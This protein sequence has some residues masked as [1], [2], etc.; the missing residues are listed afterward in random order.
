MMNMSSIRIPIRA[1]TD[2]RAWLRWPWLSLAV[3]GCMQWPLPDHEDWLAMAE[4]PAFAT[5]SDFGEPDGESLAST[6]AAQSQDGA[7][8]TASDGVAWRT[9]LGDAEAPQVAASLSATGGVVFV[10]GAVSPVSSGASDA[11]LTAISSSDGSVLWTHQLGSSE[12]DAA[13]G[14]ASRG[15]RVVIAGQTGGSLGGPAQ[16]FGDAFVAA[17]SIAGEPLWTQQLGGPN[18][19][20][21][22]GVSLDSNGAALVVGETRSAL[23]GARRGSDRDAFL[24][25]VGP[26]GELVYARQLGSSLGVDEVATSVA[27]DANG[28]VVLAG[29]TFGSV[30]GES[31]GS[32]DILVARYSSA[33][34]LL[35]T[36]QL[37]SEGYDAAEA[38]AVD[39]GGAVYV[40]GQT[41]GSIVGGPGVV[42][43]G[44]PLLAKLSATGAPLWSVELEDAE[45]GAAS[46]IVVD[47]QGDVWLSGRTAASFAA[48]NH[49]AFDS[50][51]ARFSSDGART[52]ALQPGVAD[53]D[54]AVGIALDGERLLLLSRATQS[55]EVA[56]DYA[57]LTALAA[58]L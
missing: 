9:R 6:S 27:T 51:V 8:D 3:C 39:A 58:E 53:N 43:G 28:D 11:L 32:A 54:R 14:S 18:P 24:A 23:D 52:S 34:E 44:R 31:K 2:G 33:G 57:L 17:Y 20:A 30:Q 16:G 13:N 29:H 5:A 26:D 22:F 36:A 4:P 50:F 38:I 45:M 56:F 47:A 46:A 42:F 21:A 10:A 48:P 55:G 25:K 19:D 37:G 41:G 7:A 1:R 12:P 15:D 35:W 40:A 49:G